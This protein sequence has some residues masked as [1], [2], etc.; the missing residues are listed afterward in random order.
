MKWICINSTNSLGVNWPKDVGISIKLYKHLFSYEIL[1]LLGS[2]RGA[3]LRKQFD[4]VR[5]RSRQGILSLVSSIDWQ[6]GPI[7]IQ[8]IFLKM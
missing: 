7:I 2:Y 4:Q 1:L 8:R 6:Q 5:L 3:S